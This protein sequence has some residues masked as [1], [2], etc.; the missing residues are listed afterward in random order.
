MIKAHFNLDNIQEAE[1][2]HQI[3]IETIFNHLGPSHPLLITV[4]GI[5]A[6]LLIQKGKTEECMYLY[7]SSMM[8]C[9]KALGPNHVQTAQLHMDFGQFYLLC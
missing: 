8:C 6:Y 3:S 9:M 2:F 5:M 1:R 4:Y 7:K